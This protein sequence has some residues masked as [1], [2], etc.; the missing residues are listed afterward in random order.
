MHYV[1][2]RFQ[3]FVGILGWVKKDGAARGGDGLSNSSV[4]LCISKVREKVKLGL[5]SP[6]CHLTSGPTGLRAIRSNAVV[7]VG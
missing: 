4:K 2:L 3:L 6:L 5:L 1:E 7:R